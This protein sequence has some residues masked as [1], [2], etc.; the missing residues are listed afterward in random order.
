MREI[1]GKALISLSGACLLCSPALANDSPALANWKQCA[2][3]VRKDY[4]VPP[5]NVEQLKMLIEEECGPRPT[6]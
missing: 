5:G 3:N 2:A 6:Q 4:P 1:F